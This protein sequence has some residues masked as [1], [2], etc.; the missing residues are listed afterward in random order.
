MA[1]ISTH[2]LDT[3]A[4]KFRLNL[5]PPGQTWLG[6]VDDVDAEAFDSRYMK[7]KTPSTVIIPFIRPSLSIIESLA[8]RRP[9]Y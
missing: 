5:E 3:L 9:E 6:L 2:I 4:S 7:D 1:W 8:T